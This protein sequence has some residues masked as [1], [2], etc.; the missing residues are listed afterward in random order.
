M[1][2]SR[3]K[4][5]RGLGGLTLSLPILEGLSPRQAR[6]A[7]PEFPPFAI[8][9][10]QANGVAAAQNTGEIG[11]EPERFWPDTPG[12]LAQSGYSGRAIEELEA[13]FPKLLVISGVHMDG[14]DYGDG[15][16]NGALQGLT[17]RGP[18]TPGQG[19]NSEAGG[20]SIDHRIGAE[21]NADGRESMFMYCG[22]NSGWLG[23]ACISHRGA[24]QRR[25]PLHNPLTA[26]QQMMG[27]DS[28][29][30]ADLIARQKS[31]NDLVRDQF[32]DLMSKPRLSSMDKQRLELHRDAIRDLENN[33]S[34]NFTASE[35]AELEGMAGVHEST[36]GDEVL[37]TARAHMQIA[38]LAVNCGYTRSVAIQV[39]SGNDGDTKY[40]DPDSGQPMEN[41]H[42]VSHR[43]ISHDASGAIIPG[44]DLLHHKI[45]R[46][47][48]QTFRYL[49]EQLDMRTIPDGRSLLDVGFAAW[50]NDLGNGPAHA[51]KRCPWII[52]GSADGFLR[53][54]EFVQL[55]GEQ[56]STQNHARVLNTLGSAAG[57]RDS[58][59]EYIADFGDPKFD[60][61]PI[62]ELM[63]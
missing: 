26:Y 38:A 39:G 49:L 28:D 51:P 36:D 13:F 63:A 55:P 35:V 14:F 47:F 53:Q 27:L 10:R 57:L 37:M 61:T 31:V 29:L 30:Y 34:C 3:R 9:F 5:L 21:L 60:R 15:H 42:Y 6:A 18:Q 43:R 41:F 48:A 16:A 54:G 7:D 40:R 62:P 52:G 12:P 19:G 11:E 45:D 17:A 2:I 56:W 1:S 50:Y 25:A 59:G 22:R 4:V 23:G 33:L 44:S 58:A 24:G 8:F 46:Q 20:E 32:S